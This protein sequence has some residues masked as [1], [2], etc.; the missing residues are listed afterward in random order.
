MLPLDVVLSTGNKEVHVTAAML[1]NLRMSATIPGGFAGCSFT[2]PRSMR[3]RFAELE[4]YTRLDVVD[5]RSAKVVWSGRL[6]VPGREVTG[7]GELYRVDAVGAQAHTTDITTPVIYND[8]RN[9][10]WAQAEPHAS[11]GA[12]F[13]NADTAV[14]GAPTPRVLWTLPN[15]TPV[16]TNTRSV[17]R[18][19][20]L[21]ASRQ[22]LARIEVGVT[23]GRNETFLRFQ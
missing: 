10:M 23:S 17:A 3:L 9:S 11:P 21:L 18:Y 5:T 22:K 13:S 20:G 2:I 15:G 14:T 16:V 12:T 1:D 19:Y 6:D 7:T 4:P 8:A